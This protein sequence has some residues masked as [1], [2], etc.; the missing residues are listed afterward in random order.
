M[1]RDTR[2]HRGWLPLGASPLQTAGTYSNNAG[3][4]ACADAPIGSYDPGTGN[5]QAYACPAGTYSGS[6]GQSSCTLALAGSYDSGTGNTSPTPC[7]SGTTSP[8]GASSCTSVLSFVIS[9][10]NDAIGTSVTFW[11]AHWATDN[12]PSGGAASAS[13]KG[14]ANETS[15]IPPVCG[16]TCTSDPG[17]SSGPPPGPLP[18]YL[19]V[20]VSSSVT[21]SGSTVSGNI[22]RI[23]VVKTNPGYAADPGH[24]GTGT[25]VGTIC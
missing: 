6:T 8:A 9:D 25:V 20:I 2:E 3:S 10:T 1:H 17:N 22:V 18:Q 4:A 13:F 14:F 16:G 12:V 5:T 19:A 24:P 7:P 15:S 23:V 21:K 11:G